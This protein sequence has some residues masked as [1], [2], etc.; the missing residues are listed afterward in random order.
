MIGICR[1]IVFLA[2]IAREVEEQ[3]AARDGVP[4]E[5]GPLVDEELAGF[6]DAV[7]GAELAVVDRPPVLAVGLVE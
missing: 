5:L 2:W 6:L 1:Q 4:D 7:L 3:F